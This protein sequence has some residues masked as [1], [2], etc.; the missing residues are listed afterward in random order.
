MNIFHSNFNIQKYKIKMKRNDTVRSWMSVSS[1]KC[2][3]LK[4]LK[5]QF[6]PKAYTERRDERENP[7]SVA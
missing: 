6:S 4:S 2:P 5:F 7:F 3:T 1:G